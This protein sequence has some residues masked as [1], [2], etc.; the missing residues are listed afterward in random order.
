MGAGEKST[1][2][3]CQGD[4]TE[5]GTARRA[6]CMLHA[7]ACHNIRLREAVRLRL[8]W[9]EANWSRALPG[10]NILWKKTQWERVKKQKAADGEKAVHQYKKYHDL[11]SYL[12]KSVDKIR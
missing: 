4:K 2:S 11:A 3:N 8:L 9:C 12:K 10:Y 6:L 7:K 1:V 5:P